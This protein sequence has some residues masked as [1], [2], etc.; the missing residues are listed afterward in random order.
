MLPWSAPL[1]GRIDEQVITSELLRGNPL[2]DPHERP[3]Y[4]YLPPGYDDD[5][6][7]RY[8]SVYVIQGY[9]G[10]VAMWR[11]R[12][13]VPPAVPGDGGR[14][15]RVRRGAGRDR[16]LRGRVD[17]VRRQ[18]VRGLARHRALPLVPVRRGG[19]I[20]GRE[21]PDAARR[22]APGHHGQ[23]ERRVRRHDHAHAAPGPVRC[24]RHACRGLAVRA[25][26][27]PRVRQV[28]RGTCASTTGTSSAGGRTSGP[29]PPSPRRPT[30]TC[31]CCSAC[32]PASRRARTAGWTCRSTRAPGCCGPRYGS[33]GWTGT[34][35]GWCPATR[36]NSGRCGPSGST[37]A[38]GTSGSST[39]GPRRSAARCARSASPT[40]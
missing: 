31:S 8:P 35:S 16:G 4:V 36:A 13:A 11:N 20:R 21:L 17:R 19:R 7:R 6:A 26:L 24:P 15:V 5:P 39:S 23:V 30:T 3:L 40:R 25:E 33:A 28:A 2:G 34:R 38:H 29:A 12:S 9:T 32:R 27:H 22:R 14:R 18:P 37:R 10:H 1:A